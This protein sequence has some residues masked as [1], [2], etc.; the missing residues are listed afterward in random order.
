MG[1]SLITMGTFGKALVIPGSGVPIGDI[2]PRSAWEFENQTGTLGNNYTGAQIYVGTN[3]VDVDCILEGV[4]GPQDT[5]TGLNLQPIFTGAN[6]YYSGFAAGSGYVA[7][8]GEKTT[9][10][11][12]VNKSP[13]NQP[14]GLTVTIT[15]PV[16]T[17]NALTPGIGYAPGGFTV[18]GGSGS[19]LIGVIDTITGAGATGPIATFTITNGGI[20]YKATDVLTIVDGAGTGASITLSTAPNGAVTN[21]VIDGAGANYSVGDIITVDQTGSG[22]DCKFAIA[23]VKSLLPGVAQVVKFKD[24][25]KGA[26]L[27]VAVSYIIDSSDATFLVA[28]K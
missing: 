4:V 2:D 21:A 5:V 18:T 1:Q 13:A 8:V 28:L 7:S 9:T 12:L 24:L 6:P 3:N 26:I 17:T 14:F 10:A 25:Q 11:S 15:V 19:G 16:P 20:N 27:P 23:S 22:L